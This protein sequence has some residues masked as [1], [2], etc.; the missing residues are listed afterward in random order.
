MSAV[1]LPLRRG[2][3]ST[4]EYIRYIKRLQGFEF[5]IIEVSKRRWLDIAQIFDQERLFG[6]S[7]G[8]IVRRRDLNLRTILSWL[9]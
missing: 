6:R 4:G 1:Y 3:A 2:N 5:G 9:S 7:C 8:R